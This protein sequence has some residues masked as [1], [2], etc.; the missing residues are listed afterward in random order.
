LTHVG[1]E[2]LPD[3]DDR[4]TLNDEIVHIQAIG[5]SIFIQPIRPENRESEFEP[6]SG[7]IPWE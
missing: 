5:F 1:H 6:V 7:S 2:L 3:W 4:N